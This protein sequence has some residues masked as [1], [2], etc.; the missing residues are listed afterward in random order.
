M[1]KFKQRTFSG[2]I[3]Y[4]YIFL[5]LLIFL[6][7][8]ILYMVTAFRMLSASDNNILQYSLQMVENNM[9]ALVRSINDNSKIVAF[10]E[11]IQNTLKKEGNVSYKER[12]ELQDTLVQMV[13]CCDG[14]TSIYLFDLQGENYLAGDIYEVEA[15]RFLAER[16]IRL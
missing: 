9:Q 11:V 7:C 3:R 14:I 1:K 13:A 6:L 16:Y 10:D 5:F 12:M 15:I 8:G 4:Y 2:Q